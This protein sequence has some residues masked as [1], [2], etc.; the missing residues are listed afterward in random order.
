M[1][2]YTGL[3]STQWDDIPEPKLWPKG[4]YRLK[5]AGEPK[6]G[7]IKGKDDREWEKLTIVLK[8][9]EPMSDVDDEALAEMGDYDF[10]ADIMTKEFL[11]GSKRDL[12]KVRKHLTNYGFEFDDAGKET[13][14]RSLPEVLAAL[15]DRE[16]LGY[17]EPRSYVSRDGE[18]KETN[19]VTGFAKVED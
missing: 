16:V 10:S 11:L 2:E 9:V 18:P 5:V 1:S 19:S 12:D 7:K 17:V 3:L 8:H 13:E 4:T 6:Q 14:G 15:K